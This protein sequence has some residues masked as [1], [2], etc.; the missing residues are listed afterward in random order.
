MMEMLER[1]KQLLLH[2]ITIM[3]GKQRRKGLTQ[4]SAQQGKSF[5]SSRRSRSIFDNLCGDTES[6]DSD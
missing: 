6:D 2:Q 4:D 1:F 3:M 5:S